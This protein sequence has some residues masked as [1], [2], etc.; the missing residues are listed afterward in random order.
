MI[1]YQTRQVRDFFVVSSYIER[2]GK[3]R[4]IFRFYG[5]LWKKGVLV[6]MPCLGGER[7][8]GERRAGGQEDL[9]L[10]LFSFISTYAA[11][12]GTVTSLSCPE[13]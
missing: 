10:S 13:S 2:Q 12:Q 11:C 3:D 4:V 1:H 6:S 9:A 8:E 7:G 5:W